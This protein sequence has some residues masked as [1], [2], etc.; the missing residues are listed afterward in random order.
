MPRHG[1]DLGE[2]DLI[3]RLRAAV[4]DAGAP[5]GADLV[6]GSGDDAA[7]L[8]AG[9]DVVISVDAIVEGVHFTRA[10]HPLDAVGPK[11]LATALSDLAAMGARPG[12][13]FVVLGLP[14]EEVD[15]EDLDP[16]AA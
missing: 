13:A 9:E 2:F 7:V 12:E 3:A 16:L 5:A 1:S 15:D 10:G 6:L 4:E 8:R 11:A 14:V